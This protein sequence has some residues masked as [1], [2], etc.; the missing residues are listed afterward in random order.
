MDTG[1]VR[2]GTLYSYR[3]TELGAAVGDAL[4]GKSIT[5]H[6]LA[7]AV[8]VTLRENRSWVIDKLVKIHPTAHH[9][10]FDRCL[11]TVPEESPDQYIYCASHRF[12]R[13]TLRA[14]GA[15]ACVRV[16][17]VLPFLQALNDA[18][19]ASG[20]S[21]RSPLFT[22]CD[23]SG[24]ERDEK[25]ERLHPA[26]LKNPSYKYQAE[27]RMIWQPATAAPIKPTF[28]TVPAMPRYCTLLRL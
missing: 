6:A 19:L 21:T 5:R 14:F 13:A 12:S 18:M 8:D 10:V 25:M 26:R 2:V 23:Y 20:Y 27:V 22:P 11:F 24:R 16:D 3:P 15:A 28:L 7:G 1:L 4:E 9:I 17:R